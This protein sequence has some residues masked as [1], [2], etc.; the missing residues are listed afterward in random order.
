MTPT[1]PS[2]RRRHVLSAGAALAASPLLA[3]AA[4]GANSFATKPIRLIVP[5]AA[6]GATDVMARALGDAIGKDLGQA[7]VVDNKPG[8]AGIIA[9]DAMAK[10]APDGHTWM[11]GTTSTMVTNRFL[12]RKLPF[13]PNKDLAWVGRVC[14]SPIVLAVH[15]SLPAKNV[16]EVLA[17][18]KANKGQVSYG[19]Y[20]LG[21]HGHLIC[22]YM[23][24]LAG[25]DAAHVAYKGEAP[26]ILD[27]VAGQV[28]IGMGSPMGLKP[29][30]EKIR[31]VGIIGK[32]RSNLLPDLPTFWEQNQ[33][34]APYQTLGVTAFAAPGKTPIEIQNRFAQSAARALKL[35]EVRARIEATGYPVVDDDTPA[36]FTA[37]LIRDLPL[38]QTM[39]EQA[40]VEPT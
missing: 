38:W 27:L 39:I 31:A 1:D 7:V 35:P 21:S 13:D 26:M 37:D 8:A 36:A 19:S 6:G 22:A 23:S 33:R 2:W 3:G 24:R 32:Q 14:T 12:Y 40:G 17:Y 11:L 4:H 16:A 34:D 20:G 5:F 10:S 18:M 30:L 25:A 15:Q 29:H 9:C 28:K